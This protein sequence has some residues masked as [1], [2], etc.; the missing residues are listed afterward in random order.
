MKKIIHINQHVIRKNNKTGEREPV[1]TCKTYKDNTYCHEV[2]I[3]G[4]CRVIYSPDKPLSC[5]AKVWIETTEEV[6]CG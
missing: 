2:T 1:I 5:G 3:N 6:E 4:P